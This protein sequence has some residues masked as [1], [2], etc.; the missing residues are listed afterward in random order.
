MPSPLPRPVRTF[1]ASDRRRWAAGEFTD[2]H[3]R[4]GAHPNG[5]GTWFTV[6]AP[7]AESVSVVGDFNGW[8]RDRHPMTAIGDG[9][10]RRFVRNVRPGACY[11]Y[12]LSRWGQRW[13][14]TDPY[15]FRMEP[16]APGG[17]ATNGLAA[18]V[19][20]LDYEWSDAD[21]M[22][23]RQ[24]PE[25]LTQPLA[26]YEV[27]LG[28]WRHASG[29]RMTYRE[30]AEPLADHVLGLGFTHVEFLPVMEHP[31][32]GSWGY[33]VVGFFAP[34]ARYGS[35]EDFMALVDALHQRGVGVI[36]DWVPAHF[37]PDPQGL[38]TFDGEPLFEYADPL[39][40]THPDWGTYVFDYGRPEVQNYLLSSA[41]FWLDRYHIDGIRVD[42]VASMLYRDYSRTEWSPNAHGGRE[43]LEAI[44]LLQRF[45]AE[46]YAAHPTALTFAEESTAWPGVTKPTDTGGLGFLYKW[47]MGW[48][49][50]T[51]QY[52]REEPIHRQHHHDSIT[53]PLV[54]AFS[55]QFVLP[56]SHDEVVHGKGSLW[57]KMPGDDW[58]KAA[59][60][61][62][63]YAH[64]MG[65]PGKKLLFMG[66]EFGQPAEW[67]H[68]QPLDWPLAETPLHGGI[69]KWVRTL[70]ALYAE[71]PA[72]WDDSPEAFE[73]IDYGD[74]ASSIVSY[75]RRAGGRTLLF[76][77]N[78][79]PVVRE[80]YRVG[81]PEGGRWRVVLNSDDLAFGGSGVGPYDTVK[82]TTDGPHG[83]PAGLDLTLPPLAALILEPVVE[84]ARG[85]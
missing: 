29:E 74:K 69:Q 38:V 32:Y 67:D 24:G 39:M 36:L 76:V 42:A 16:P 63:L 81:T 35:P 59:N 51:L 30:I 31:Y 4:M 75:F 61:R 7:R 40:R 17:S 49:H 64:M 20:D 56:L 52:F 77:L 73:W 10:W 41:R 78:A 21:W 1:P 14:K 60:L 2:S 47:N 53:F 65:H 55:E 43:N 54:Y 34:T 11:K 84:G 26:I 27:H 15:A 12:S 79:T 13:E 9:L 50:D 33:Q 45:N 19:T 28:S 71:N 22:A 80:A 72:L 25:T 58:Q 3:T 37:A 8:D 57:G 5:A 46:V 85:E 70:N 44:T 83:R 82:A 66:Q 62:L 48:M 23:S 68:D 18:V 6:W